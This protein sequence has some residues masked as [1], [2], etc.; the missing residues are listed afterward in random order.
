MTVMIGFILSE[1]ITFI[2]S[3]DWI[4]PKYLEALSNAVN[5]TGCE[6]SICAYEETEGE[7]PAVDVNKLKTAVQNAGKRVK[8]EI[9][10]IRG[11]C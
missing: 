2:D 11:D 6:I 9:A 10:P 3:D 1:W 4:H 7:L 8:K 5:E